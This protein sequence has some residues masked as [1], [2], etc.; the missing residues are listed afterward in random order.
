MDAPKVCQ[1]K[2]IKQN[3]A[4]K[5]ER[6]GALQKTQS[7]ELSRIYSVTKTE[8]R[9]DEDEK[10]KTRKVW[11]PSCTSVGEWEKWEAEETIQVSEKFKVRVKAKERKRLSGLTE[12]GR[13]HV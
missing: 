12:I 8:K 11:G 3:Q 2:I 13:A 1:V 10:R 7:M 9:N 4:T 6:Q 5:E